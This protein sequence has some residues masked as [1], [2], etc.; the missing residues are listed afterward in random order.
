[1]KE[2]MLSGRSFGR[3]LFDDI[4]KFKATSVFGFT[5]KRTPLWGG[6][7]YQNNVLSDTT[8]HKILNM[9]IHFDLVLSNLLYSDQAYRRT[10]PLLEEYHAAGNG[11][12]V[13]T[14][15]LAEKIRKDFPKYRIKASCIRNPRSISSIERSLE[16][17][18]LVSLQPNAIKNRDF[19]SSICQ[20]IRDRVIL[21]G[22][23]SCLYNCTRPTCYT[24]MSQMNFGKPAT[25]GCS[26]SGSPML[27]RFYWFNYE[28]AEIFKGFPLIKLV[29]PRPDSNI[30]H[31]DADTG[32]EIRSTIQWQHTSI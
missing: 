31:I 19:I 12:V 20:K 23:S 2:I 28:E 1:M 7:I 9:G 8:V 24:G 17:F 16:L 29:L 6:R 11:V 14:N 3:D 25:G 15:K 32:R 26:G 13:T 21:F 5:E 10:I 18:D 22:S 30:I 4:T 27:K